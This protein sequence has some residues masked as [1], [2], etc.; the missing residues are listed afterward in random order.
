MGLKTDIFNAYEQLMSNGGTIELPQEILDNLDEFT[1]Q[2]VEAIK[3]FLTKQTW[4]ITDLKAFVE[5]DE[6][7][8]TQAQAGDIQPG[9]T[10]NVVGATNTGALLPGATGTTTGTPNG[11]LIQKIK[12]SKGGGKTGGKMTATGHAFVGSE[13]HYPDL[14]DEYDTDGDPQGWNPFSKVKIESFEAD[15]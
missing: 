8:I 7:E 11:V 6:L 15:E 9:V 12:G 3:V 13:E 2:F 5:L 4:Q 1:L 10:S 14:F